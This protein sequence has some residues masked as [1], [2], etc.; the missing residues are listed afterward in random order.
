M[1]DADVLTR[2]LH[3]V[4][5]L[6]WTEIRR[7]FS[8]EVRVDYT[9]MSGGEPETLAADDLIGRWRR[10]LPGFDATQHITGPVLLSTDDEPGVRADAHVRGYHRLGSETWAI[11]GHYVA[12]LIDGRIA[13]LTL[14][15]FYQEGDLA[16]PEEATKRA[17]TR[18]REPRSR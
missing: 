17:G 9:E 6:D 4:D 16:L 2:L 15:V 7:C 5:R 18:P 3:A 1:S 13:A 8:D 12:R 14:Q 10:L 11:H